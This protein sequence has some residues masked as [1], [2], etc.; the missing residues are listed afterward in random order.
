[1]RAPGA[2]AAAVAILVFMAML[3]GPHLFPL[4]LHGL[5]AA[6]LLSGLLPTVALLSGVSTWYAASPGYAAKYACLLFLILFEVPLRLPPLCRSQARWRGMGT[7]VGVLILGC[8]FQ[9]DSTER[10]EGTFAN[11]NN[12]ALA[13]DEGQFYYCLLKRCHESDLVASALYT[14]EAYLATWGYK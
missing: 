6:L 9:G 7:V 3:G 1:M 5:T 12:H 2:T 14:A 13:C 11:P 4:P 8:L 10:M